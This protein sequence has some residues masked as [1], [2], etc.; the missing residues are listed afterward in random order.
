MTPTQY[1]SVAG[2]SGA[3]V[4]RNAVSH[5]TATIAPYPWQGPVMPDVPPPS[6]TTA[7]G[8]DPAQ[9]LTCASPTGDPTGTTV[10]V[11]H[12]GFW[13]TEWDRAHTAPPGAGLRRRRST[14]S[15]VVEY[16]RTGM[17]GGGW[18]GTFSDVWRGRQ[19][20]SLADPHPFRTALSSSARPSSGGHLYVALAATR[21]EA[22]RLAGVVAPLAGCVDLALTRDL[23]LGDGA[24]ARFMGDADAPGAWTAADPAAPIHFS[25]GSCSSTA[26]PMTRSPVE[27]AERF[28]DRQGSTRRPRAAPGPARRR[29]HGAHR[30]RPARLPE[31]SSMRWPG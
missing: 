13:K 31:W 27:V 19:R 4:S 7:Y 17:R 22:G 5:A 10:M 6:R 28:L 2:A 26:R 15:A 23:G 16:R 24:A 9:V 8:I 1:A 14:T 20:G 18:P 30:A 21:P 12:G 25:R 29:P 11:V 3:A